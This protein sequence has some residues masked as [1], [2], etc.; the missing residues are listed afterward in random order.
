[1]SRLIAL[2]HSRALG[3][4]ENVFKWHGGLQIVLF[5]YIIV[6]QCVEGGDRLRRQI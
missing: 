1:M 4:W 6:T 3:V 2:G 5:Y